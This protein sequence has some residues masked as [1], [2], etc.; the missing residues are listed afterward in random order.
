MGMGLL[1]LYVGVL[2]DTYMFY[3]IFSSI[4]HLPS[5]C[6]VFTNGVYTPPP[7]PLMQALTQDIPRRLHLLSSHYPSWNLARIVR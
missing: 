4:Y 3:A 6:L 7:P 1:L 2:C 5:F